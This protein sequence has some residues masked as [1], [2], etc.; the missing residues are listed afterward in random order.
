LRTKFRGK[1]MEILPQGNCHVILKSTGA[2][3]SWKK[4]TTSVHNIIVGKLYVDHYGTLTVTNHQNNMTCSINFQPCG[5]SSS[6]LGVIQGS[7]EIAGKERKL[8]GHWTDRVISSDSNMKDPEVIWRKHPLPEN[9]A[10]NW[11]YTTFA[12]T[13]NECS[14]ELRSALCPTDARMRPDQR[15]MEEGQYDLADS[16]KA[17]LEAKQRETRKRRECDNAEY[18]PKW[19]TKD[20]DK[21]SGEEHW[22]F[23]VNDRLILLHLIQ[24]SLLY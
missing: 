22:V 20:V 1:S 12:M 14:P 9:S 16:E 5:W 19:F 2:H 23:S 24:L 15:A 4:V 7:V 18:S 10:K 6:S 3:F 21:D 13:L 8:S 17:R 11:H